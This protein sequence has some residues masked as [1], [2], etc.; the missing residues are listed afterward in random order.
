MTGYNI[1]FIDPV[2]DPITRIAKVRIELNNSSG[3]F[4]PEMLAAGI[5]KTKL[6]HTGNAIVVPQSAILWTG[7]RS[8]IYVKIPNTTEPTF[9]MRAV[10][11]GAYLQNSYEI[12]DGLT[13]GEEVVT[14]GTFSVDAT[15]QLAGKVSMMN[16]NAGT[17]VN[18]MP[19]MDMGESTNQVSVEKKEMNM[20]AN[21][22]HSN[23]KVSGNC[24]MC[25]D[26]IE[27]TAKKISG[28]SSVEW[29]IKTKMFTVMFDK[30]KTNKTSIQKA[31]ASAGHDTEKQ[32][33][34]DD[35]YNNLPECCK[36]RNK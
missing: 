20:E 19:G 8:L 24:E 4:K 2:I 27:S 36:Y 11:L 12:I 35:V 29:N 3:I 25:K 10:T 17:K 1:S 18:S 14:N 21:I 9:K 26:R 34:P 22:E 28:V 16:D 5:V 33:A 13:E 30:N 15:A 23:F 31:I 7:K 6:E 32:I